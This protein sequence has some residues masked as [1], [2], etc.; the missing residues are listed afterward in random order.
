M[1][2]TRIKLPPSPEC[3]PRSK[4]AIDKQSLEERKPN[5]L[6]SESLMTHKEESLRLGIVDSFPNQI[7]AGI[8]ASLQGNRSTHS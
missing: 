5:F 4:I 7:R 8:Q 2:Q 3:D 6:A 1:D